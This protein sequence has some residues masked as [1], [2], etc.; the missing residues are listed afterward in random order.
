MTW[1]DERVSDSLE[2][3]VRDLAQAPATLQETIMADVECVLCDATD[4]LVGVENISDPAHHH[5]ACAWRRAREWVAHH[6]RASST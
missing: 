3:I 5:P 1:E 2:A 4:M 6:Q